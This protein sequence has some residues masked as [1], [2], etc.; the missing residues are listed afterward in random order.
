VQSESADDAGGGQGRLEHGE[1]LADAGSWT[2]AEGQVRVAVALFFLLGRLW[3]SAW[4]EFVH[5]LQFDREI[6]TIICTTNAIES[7]NARIRRARPTPCCAKH[8]PG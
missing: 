7:I 4:A 8:S 3:T 1:I 5:F 2:A 6:R